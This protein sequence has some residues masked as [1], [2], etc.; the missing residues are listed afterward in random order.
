[1]FEPLFEFDYEHA[2]ILILQA[3]YAALAVFGFLDLVITI[4]IKSTKKQRKK[5][6]EKLD[7]AKRLALILKVVAEVTK[8]VVEREIKRLDDVG[9]L[10]KNTAPVQSQNATKLPIWIEQIKKEQDEKTVDVD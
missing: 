6:K 10:P 5:L 7:E 8:K 9:D 1:M 4:F 3:L 2:E